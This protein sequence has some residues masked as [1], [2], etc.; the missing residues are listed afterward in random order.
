MMVLIALAGQKPGA[1]AKN[2]S[3]LSKKSKEIT[4]R[5]SIVPRPFITANPSIL[6]FARAL[7]NNPDIGAD[8]DARNDIVRILTI[9]IPPISENH[10][11]KTEAIKDNSVTR[12]NLKDK[13]CPRDNGETLMDVNILSSLSSRIEKAK[14]APNNN[15]VINAKKAKI[16]SA[17]RSIE[18]SL[19]SDSHGSRYLPTTP[20]II[21]YTNIKPVIGSLIHFFTSVPKKILYI[22]YTTFLNGIFIKSS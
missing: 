9:G 4:G 16:K 12:A 18:K 5:K 17:Y 1:I 15:G 8:I 7:M 22:L 20:K 6:F 14:I 13:N 3:F 11:I 21:G 10:M 2:S 19:A